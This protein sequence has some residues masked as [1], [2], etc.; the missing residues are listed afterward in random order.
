MAGKVKKNFKVKDT[1]GVDNI[2]V[3]IPSDIK[4]RF[5]ELAIETGRTMSGLGAYLIQKF[6]KDVDNGNITI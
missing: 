6:I 1:E 2:N 3:R 5:N 4:D